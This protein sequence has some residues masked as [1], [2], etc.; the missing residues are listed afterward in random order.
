MNMHKA[1]GLIDIAEQG[2]GRSCAGSSSEG[3]ATSPVERTAV[4]SCSA[5]LYDARLCSGRPLGIE[6]YFIQSIPP[7]PKR[8]PT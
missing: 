6:A 8:I 3:V 7:L 5:R 4:M 2:G 1:S